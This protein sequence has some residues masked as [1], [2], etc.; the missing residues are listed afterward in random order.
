MKRYLSFSLAIVLLS[1]LLACNASESETPIAITDTPAA[2]NPPAS[3]TPYAT[4]PSGDLIAPD[5]F[6]YLGA[7]RLPGGDDPPRTFAYGGNAIT[8]NPDND[9]GNG[10]LF[11]MGHD[12]VAYGDVPDGN[13]VAEIS[14]PE[15]V[16]SRNL[17]DLPYAEFRQDFHNVTAGY[18]TELEEIPKVGLQ[19]LNY[20]ATG[21]KIHIA[22]GQHLQPDGIPSHGWFSADLADPDFQGT[23][24]IGDQNLYSTNGYMFD[25]PADWA[26]TYVQGRYLATGRM[27]DGG[28]G[29][30]GPTLF[31]YRPWSEDG[32]SPSPGTHLPETTL[33]LYENAYNT[34]NIERAM[35]GYQHPDEWEG[36]AWL[37]TASGKSA[38]LFA[39]TKSTGTKYW[40]GFIH[41]DGPEFPCVDTHA[42]FTAC[43]LADG[44]P[45]PPED[46]AGCCNEDAGTCVSG[47]GWWSTRFDAQFILYDPAQL[48]QVAAGQ[49]E[50]WMPQPYA[51][52][53]L[54]EH[55]YLNPPEW[56]VIMLGWGDQRRNRIG[57]VA[58]DR[59]GGRLY[60]LELYAD[61]GKPVVHVWQV[62]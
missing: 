62:E 15:P 13:Q 60:V 42:D 46:F 45:C 11:V 33:L 54:D 34:E 56:D 40:Y 18:F 41:R 1:V 28:Q 16:D 55:L 21:P 44:T 17:D 14:I 57:A 35:N 37:T 26:D 24:F 59:A 12:R 10:T 31:A 39:G 49:L 19:Y 25:I 22:W 32:S 3:P 2:V 38:V 29:G 61:G 23:W 51:I 47:R 58:F 8:F 30:M 9:P 43:R 7:F 50:S 48:A 6:T 27:R 5:D 52:I 36:G 20:P 53:D 4:P